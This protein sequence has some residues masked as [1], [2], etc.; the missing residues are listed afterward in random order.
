MLLRIVLTGAAACLLNLG[1]SNGSR[2]GQLTRREQALLE[3]ER[4]FALKEADYESL[5]RMRD[6]LLRQP[7]SIPPQGDSRTDRLNNGSSW[8]PA[9]AGRWKSSLVCKETSCPGYVI[10]DQLSNTWE[11]FSDSTGSFARVFNKEKLIRVFSGDVDSGRPLLTLSDTSTVPENVQVS[12]ILNPVND[13][14]VTGTQVV[15]IDQCSATF[16]VELE[17]IRN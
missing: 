13:D 5:K 6:S 11:F 9:I 14:F 4:Q 15:R 12:V 10:G 3:K 8:P 17:R 1:C 2:D 16:S 7:D